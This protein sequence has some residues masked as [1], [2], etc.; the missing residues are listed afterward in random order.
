MVNE[1]VKE[2]R[3][4][5]AEAGVS[6]AAERELL[7]FSLEER[8]FAVDLD[9]VVQIIGYLEPAVPPKR[10]PHV[11]GIIE[12]RGDFI[13][14]MNLR[15]WLGLEGVVPLSKS[16]IVVL[17][18]AGQT[19]G[20]LVDA[21]V[22]VLPQSMEAVTQPPPKLQGVKSD[23]L[24]GVFNLNGRPLLWIKDE[25]LVASEGEVFGDE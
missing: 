13:P 19:V 21:V 4:S 6:E 25:N 24:Q 17:K 11:E 7:I 15:K 18:L 16:V 14:L 3:E 8:L 1:M 12:F 22:R 10:Y 23:Y 5:G 20:L 9:K 2:K